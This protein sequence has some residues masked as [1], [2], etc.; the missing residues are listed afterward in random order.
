MDDCQSSKVPEMFSTTEKQIP[1]DT[2]VVERNRPTTIRPIS[3]NVSTTDHWSSTIERRL[4]QTAIV[5][6]LDSS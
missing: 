2:T 6:T 3:M 4:T 5:F 1:N